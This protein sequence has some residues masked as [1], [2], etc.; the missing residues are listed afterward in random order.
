VL[1]SALAPRLADAVMKFYHDD[2][3][4]RLLAGQD[5]GKSQA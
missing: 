4:K 2:L 3:A 1:V 5:L